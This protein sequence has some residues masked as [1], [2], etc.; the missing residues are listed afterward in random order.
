M[1]VPGRPAPYP[2]TNPAVGIVAGPRMFHMADWVEG[3]KTCKEQHDEIDAK[4]ECVWDR[5]REKKKLEMKFIREVLPPTGNDV[6]NWMIQT[7]C[8]GYAGGEWNFNTVWGWKYDCYRAPWHLQG[9]LKS[10]NG[11]GD[12]GRNPVRFIYSTQISI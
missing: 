2:V 7:C 3:G 1:F 9:Y 11:T 4:F 5:E 8:P 12:S 6:R 10:P